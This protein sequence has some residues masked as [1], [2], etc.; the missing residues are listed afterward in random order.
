MEEDARI[1]RE[2]YDVNRPT[3]SLSVKAKGVA[4]KI[5]RKYL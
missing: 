5:K 2:F 4:S 3:Q 1:T